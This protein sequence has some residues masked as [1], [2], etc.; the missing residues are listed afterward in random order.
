MVEPASRKL[1]G[2]VLLNVFVALGGIVMAWPIIWMVS[3]SFKR[4]NEIYAF[5]P[6]IIPR[7]FTLGNYQRL[8]TDWPFGRWYTNSL[9]IAVLV[10]LAVL[11]STGLGGGNL[12]F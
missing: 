3:A 1:F 2:T 11:P 9:L 4:L 5:P 8:F 12:C 10:T 6:T 7:T